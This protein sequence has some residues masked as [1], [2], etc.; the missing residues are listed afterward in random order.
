[1]E[2]HGDSRGAPGGHSGRGAG[3][4]GGELRKKYEYSKKTMKSGNRDYTR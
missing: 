2:K 1:M 3:A 4:D